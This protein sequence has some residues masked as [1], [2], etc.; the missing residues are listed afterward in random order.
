MW[1]TCCT[2]YSTYDADIEELHVLILIEYII[3]FGEYYISNINTY[4]HLYRFRTGK[5]L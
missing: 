1:S 4:F 2:K 5:S 3:Y